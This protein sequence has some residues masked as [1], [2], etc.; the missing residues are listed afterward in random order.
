MLTVNEFFYDC[1]RFDEEK[2][3]YTVYYLLKNGLVRG[4]D[5]A[6]SIN[7]S[8]IDEDTLN[9]MIDTNEL[10]L[11]IIKLYAVPLEDMHYAIIFAENEEQ[12]RGYCFN[13]FRKIPQKI[14][15]MPQSKM[16]TTFWFPET[17]Q[18]KSLRQLKDEQVSFP[19]TAIIYQKE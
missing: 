17:N 19:C 6:S 5:D 18:Y 8:L 1:I 7:W 3:A 11:K 15:E 13:A 12:A 16:E 10:N 4:T 14:I 9:R 2:M